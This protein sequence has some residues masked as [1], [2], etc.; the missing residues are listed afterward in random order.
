MNK[1]G[2]TD[3]LEI[4]ESIKSLMHEHVR[5]QSEAVKLEGLISQLQML[6]HTREEF[7][8]EEIQRELTPPLERVPIGKKSVKMTQVKKK[9][10]LKKKKAA[11]L[12]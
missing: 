7:K 4:I 6:T 12:A 1:E 8:E 3:P 9:K 11:P 5:D 10:S 2:E